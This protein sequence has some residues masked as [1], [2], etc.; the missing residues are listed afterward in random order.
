E[1]PFLTTF[2][3]QTTLSRDALT[4]PP[5]IRWFGYPPATILIPLSA[6]TNPEPAQE[7]APVTHTSPAEEIASSSVDA[8]Q[9]HAEVPQAEDEEEEFF[10]AH[11]QD[12]VEIE[13]LLSEANEHKN[14]GNQYFATGRY[15]EAI[16]EYE[17][18]LGICPEVK[19][20][21]R[22]V[23]WGNIGACYMK[24]V[25]YVHTN[26]SHDG[27]A[28]QEDYKQAEEA[29]TESLTLSPQYAKSLL[30][31]AQAREK[32]GTYSAMSDAL[33]DYRALRDLKDTN[34]YTR[35][36]CEKA[37]RRLPPLLKERMEK[38]KEEM[39]GKLKDLGN[40]LLGKFGLS[41]DNFQMKQDPGS[42][43]YSMNFVNNPK[44]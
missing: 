7:V 5:G 36:E 9:N 29:C 6:M 32:L 33:E 19:A 38:E 14:A 34:D 2:V 31:R 15:Q 17:E 26:P 10:D 35:H 28:P 39:L 44:K 25:E 20:E 27:H 16:S 42:G 23:Y 3:R 22:A 18:A 8:N 30:R 37:E 40:T 1:L 12:P 43:S 41:T 21:E 11:E 13:R 24:M 4:K